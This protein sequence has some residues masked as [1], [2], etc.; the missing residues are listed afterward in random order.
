[1]LECRYVNDECLSDLSSEL[2]FRSLKMLSS[3]LSYKSLY[4]TSNSKQVKVYARITIPFPSFYKPNLSMSF[5]I[6]YILAE[7]SITHIPKRI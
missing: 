7:L 2:L 5:D 6:A 4:L 1:M 3:Y